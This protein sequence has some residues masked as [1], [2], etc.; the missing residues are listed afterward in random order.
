VFA[1]DIMDDTIDPIEGDMTRYL[2]KLSCWELSRTVR[3]HCQD[4]GFL[5]LSLIPS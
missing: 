5:E 2:W 1:A 3:S 4:G